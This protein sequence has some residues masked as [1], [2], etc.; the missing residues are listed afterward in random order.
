MKRKCLAVGIILLFVGTCFIPATAQNV[1]KPLQTS[2]SDWL[3]VGGSG[4]G[5]YT[6]I[7]SAID[8]ASTGDTVFVYNGTY[9]E[10]VIISKTIDL[11]GEKRDN[12][13]ID[14]GSSGDVLYV[15][16][17]GVTISG[18]TVQNSDKFNY[19]GIRLDYSNDNTIMD[20]TI[21]VSNHQKSIFLSYSSNNTVMGNSVSNNSFSI[22]LSYSNN[23]TIMRNNVSNN[24]EGITLSYSSNN[25]I[26]GNN[27]SNNENGIF[28]DASSNNIV[29]GNNVSNHYWGI[30]LFDHG[31]N[32]HFYHNNLIN[33]KYNAY[34][35]GK[36]TWDNGYPS[37]GNYWSDYTGTDDDSDGIGDTPYIIK[38][39]N[40][41]LYPLIE[42]YGMT[43][44][45]L[46]FKGGLFK[47]SGI[48]KNTGNT[49]AFNVQWNI[50]NDGGIIL[51]G[52]ES[53]GT[54]PKPLRPGEETQVSSSLILGF[55]KIR[56]TIAIWADNAPY[57]SK[58]TPGTLFLFFVKI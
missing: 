22:Y 30:F 6:L 4:P 12:T 32:N 25:I 46:D 23:N 44:L 16:S 41:D 7:Q 10:N 33:N 26:T 1:E 3:Y 19:S 17:D 9:T 56:I 11:I 53:S 57:V 24:Y 28:L 18:F 48:I 54:L 8:N 14:G 13:I 49:T 51:V 20:N 52:R 31:N 29:T 38:N 42:P 2:R 21:I 58:S 5:N 55:G 34:D 45:S 40:K 35:D 37:G 39:N 43:T 47:W 50:V 15:S 36:N 27:V